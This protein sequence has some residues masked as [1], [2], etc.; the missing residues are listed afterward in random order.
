MAGTLAMITPAREVRKRLAQFYVSP[1]GVASPVKIDLPAGSYAPEFHY[2][3]A[4]IEKELPPPALA[5]VV[6][7]PPKRRRYRGGRQRCGA[8]CRG[9]RSTPRSNRADTTPSGPAQV[10]FSLGTR[11]RPQLQWIFSTCSL[12]LS[13]RTVR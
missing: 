11:P 4:L 8:P 5:P 13:N 6:V 7:A 9:R 10:D 1:E 12:K 3:A 2:T